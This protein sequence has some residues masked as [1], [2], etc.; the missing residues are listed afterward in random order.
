MIRVRSLLLGLML[1]TTSLAASAGCPPDRICAEDFLRRNDPPGDRL[2]FR[3]YVP[4]ACLGHAGCPLLLFLH[5]AGE[6]G[7]D[8]QSQ[9]GN[10]ANG[11]MQ[12]VY[13]ARQAQQ[14]MIMVAP[15]CCLGE[16][17][18]WGGQKNRLIDVLEQVRSEFSYDTGRIYL[19]GISMGGGGALD[20]IGSYNGLFAAIVPVCPHT[21]YTAG[22]AAWARTP[23]WFFHAVDDGT[24]TVAH[25]RNHVAA[26]RAA[27]G[28]PLY[29][30]FATG[31]HAIWT[32]TYASA[33]LFGWLIAQRLGQ[34]NVAVEPYVRLS[35]PTAGPVWTT[36][37]ATLDLAGSA[38]SPGAAIES[39]RWFLGAASGTAAGVSPWS[40]DAL[41]LGTG[42]QTVR[43]QARGASDDA[44]LGGWTEA[45]TSLRVT[46]P[47]LDN[48]APR[49]FVL[50]EAV[51]HAGQPLEL[52]ARVLDDGLPAPATIAL[53]WTLEQ[54]PAG[55]VLE[56]DPA[57]RHRARIAAP[58]AGRYRIRVVAD[59]GAAQGQFV[60]QVLVL[61]AGI[62]P[63]VAL[64]INTGG[65]AYA[66]ADGTR[67]EADA[68][69]YGSTEAS[70]ASGPGAL[71]GSADDPLHHDYRISYGTWGYR[72]PVPP[73][74]YF[75]ELHFAETYNP[76]NSAGCRVQD[77]RVQGAPVLD[78]FSVFALAGQRNAVRYGFFA[79]AAGG[80]I[81]IALARSGG[82]GE[83][84]RL[85]AVRVLRLDGLDETVFADGFEP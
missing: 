59:D 62:A 54:A 72:L 39:V 67:Y 21:G 10:A 65:D 49:V 5:G 30:E 83:R 53:D 43:M 60:Q 34:P 35:E 25:S 58:A 31:G 37:A 23:A 36:S 51:V 28:D 82:Q 13:P 1:S 70:T 9:L 66:A 38:G 74:E 52:R 16:G 44:A 7:T 4:P 20:L 55:V 24:V 79:Q 15:Q 12:L 56:V 27:A 71:F 68:H 14:P 3:I 73:G 85:D 40:V 19:T 84:S 61:P 63:P 32:R 77:V 26:L 33:R 80:E 2:P 81:E 41:A 45:S 57:D 6:T 11:A 47:V 8:N 69:F 75:V 29:T 76:C 64:A 17:G 46:T 18:Q 50:S 22:D 78:R 48:A 42:T